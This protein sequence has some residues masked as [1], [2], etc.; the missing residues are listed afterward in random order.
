[1]DLFSSDMQEKDQQHYSKVAHLVGSWYISTQLEKLPMH[2]S[3]YQGEARVKEIMDS[4]NPRC[5]IETTHMELHVFQSLCHQLEERGL[6]LPT[7]NMS[8]ELQV[9]VFLHIVGQNVS[10]RQTQEQFQLSGE[11]VHQ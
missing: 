1:M 5:M 6:V 11:T 4:P 2:T 10:N 3:P 7:T 9:F 8:V